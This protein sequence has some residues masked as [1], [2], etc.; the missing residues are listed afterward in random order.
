MIAVGVYCSMSDSRPGQFVEIEAKLFD[1]PKPLS[2]LPLEFEII[3]QSVSQAHQ[4][5][6]VRLLLRG[7][8]WDSVGIQFA[9]YDRRKIFA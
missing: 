9:N 6:R 8:L 7:Q 2:K 5:C 4:C 1:N 3:N